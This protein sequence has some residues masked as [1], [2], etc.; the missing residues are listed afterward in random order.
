MIRF[1]V[2]Q[3]RRTSIVR[4]CLQVAVAIGSLVPI[5]AGLL[6]VVLGPA[7]LGEGGRLNP[8]MDSHYRYLSGLLMGIGFGF[9]TT[10]PDIEKKT[11]RFQLLAA[12]VVLGGLA[13]L[14]SLLAVG[15]P[16][17]PMLFGLTMELVIVPLLALW[18]YTVA[19]K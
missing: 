2:K 3:K 7:L 9:W 17:L 8:S 10:V 14:Y 18:Q 19:R 16:D 13:R 6:G 1:F 12:I 4:R 15:M 5:L 11:A